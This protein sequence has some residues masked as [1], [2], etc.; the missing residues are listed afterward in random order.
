[1]LQIVHM[2]TINLLRFHNINIICLTLLGLATP[3]IWVKT[4]LGNGLLPGDTKPLPESSLTFHQWVSVTCTWQEFHMGQVAENSFHGR[5]GP[6][7][8]KWCHGYW[9]TGRKWLID[10]DQPVQNKSDGCTASISLG[11][12]RHACVSYLTAG[13]YNLQYRVNT[14]SNSIP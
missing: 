5:Q 6:T 14:A 13:L 2:K 8:L 12:T 9:R 1:M 4:S 7:Y 10:K 11:R 3:Y